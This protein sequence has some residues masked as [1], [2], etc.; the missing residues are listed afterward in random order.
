MEQPVDHITAITIHKCTY[1]KQAGQITVMRTGNHNVTRNET[2]FNT[3]VM[4]EM[5]VGFQ[6]WNM[7]FS[8]LLKQILPLKL[9]SLFAVCTAYSFHK[10]D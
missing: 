7:N 9:S 5:N 3:V 10:M 6:K 2:I 1:C 8:S 4:S